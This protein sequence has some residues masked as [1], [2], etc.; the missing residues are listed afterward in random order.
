M[1]KKTIG[2]LMLSAHKAK[3]T[4][5]AFSKIALKKRL[6]LHQELIRIAQ[7]ELKQGNTPQ[8]Q[9]SLQ[10]NQRQVNLIMKHLGKLK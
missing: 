7:L 2:N 8:A 4:H 1:P 3:Q 10:S 5:G 6:Q 9:D